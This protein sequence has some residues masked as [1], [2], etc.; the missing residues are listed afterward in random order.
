MFW[1]RAQW[2]DA[3]PMSSCELEVDVVAADIMN[4]LDVGDNVGGNPGLAALWDDERQRRRHMGDDSQ[5][6]SP[7]SSPGNKQTSSRNVLSSCFTQLILYT[8]THLVH[9]KYM[10]TGR[11]RCCDVDSR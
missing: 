8:H 10:Y 9:F 7:P 4:R 11:S 6:I 5:H 3:S 2:L 1:C